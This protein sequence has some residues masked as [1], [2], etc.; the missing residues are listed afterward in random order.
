MTEPLAPP[1]VSIWMVT[2]NHESFI[3]K[4][5]K[6]VL[7]QETN[8]EYKLLIGDDFSTDKTREIC[9]RYQE[10]FPDKIRL[11][12]HESN[13]G[14]LQNGIYMYDQCFKS[15]SK[16]VAMLEGDDYWTDPQKLQKQVDF[17]ESNDGYAAHTHNSEF[18]GAR[19]G[20]FSRRPSGD[21]NAS[22]LVGSRPFHSASLLFR[23]N[24]MEPPFIPS[25]ILSGDRTLF[26]HL[27]GH[28][29]IRYDDSPMTVYRKNE[30][31]ISGNVTVAQMKKDLNM[32][33]FFRKKKL[34]IPY[35]KLKRFIFETIILYPVNPKRTQLFFLYLRYFWYCLL[36][37]NFNTKVHRSMLRKIL[38]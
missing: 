33:S 34:K 7:M 26:L 27:A 37:S 31:G 9:K 21:L 28:G 8:F 32:I 12:F 15:N 6:S 2:Y 30:G 10:E 4:A 1:L 20:V 24:V 18:I 5:I 36:T 11:F 13:L 16:Y 38:K 23:R 29:P 35:L 3:E 25:N 22:N 19:S 17:M 14:A